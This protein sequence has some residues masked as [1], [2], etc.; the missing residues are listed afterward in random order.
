MPNGKPNILVLWGDDIG[1]Y[2][3]SYNNRG[4]MGYETRA[5]TA[6]ILL[7]PCI[8]LHWHPQGGRA[9]ESYGED[10]LHVGK[11][12]TMFVK[13]VQ[14]HVMACPKHYAANNQETR[15]MVIDVGLV[16]E[17][18]TINPFDFF[19]EEFAENFPFE[20]P[21]QLHKELKPYFECTESGP[22]LTCW[23]QDVSHE[24]TRI[25]DFLVALNQRLE[26]GEKAVFLQAVFETR[27]REVVLADLEFPA[28]VYP[29][30][31]QRRHGVRLQPEYHVVGDPA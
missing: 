9:Q 21:R 18:V 30:A 14:E 17:M 11:M 12:G 15:R 25:V 8:N 20:Y 26:R 3:I 22:R 13:G 10:P 5:Q 7:A 2:N 16:V 29:W 24:P 19:V 23:L 1:W 4:V 31:A 27:L 6:T 28:N